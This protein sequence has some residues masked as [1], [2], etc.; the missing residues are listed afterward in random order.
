MTSH[1]PSIHRLTIGLSIAVAVAG[2]AG[3]GPQATDSVSQP[4]PAATSSTS[5]SIPSDVGTNTMGSTAP[6]TS[7]QST[8]PRVGQPVPPALNNDATPVGAAP[9]AVPAPANATPPQPP[10]AQA[11]AQRPM[12]SRSV[13]QAPSGARL[14]QVS[15]IEPIRERPP[16]TGKGAVVGGVLGAVVGNQF[17]HGNGKAAMT[18]L[19]AAGGAVTGNNV[20]RNINKRVV[21][22]R[23]T[24]RLDNGRLRTY[25]EPRI[26]G[27]RVGD[28]VRIDGRH[29]RRA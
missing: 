28:R 26:E 10:T 5:A 13:A 2:M 14:G 29:V 3:C 21:G 25:E 11:Q 7:A 23:V 9:V 8:A 20:E 27:L 19:G 6:V 15:S 4:V 16:G 18:V 24:V 22:Y 12:T 17:G 1:R